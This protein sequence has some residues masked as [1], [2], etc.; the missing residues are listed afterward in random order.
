MIKI[1]DF[2]WYHMEL[3]YILIILLYNFTI[4]LVS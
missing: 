4:M 1:I 2:Q 3:A